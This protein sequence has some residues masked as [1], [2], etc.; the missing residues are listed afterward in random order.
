MPSF[1]ICTY[2]A[3]NEEI[4]RRWYAE[5]GFRVFAGADEATTGFFSRARAIN[6]AARQAYTTAPHLHT[7][8]LADND[9]IPSAPH[10]LTALE[11]SAYYSCITP[12]ITTLHTS[13]AGRMQLLHNRSTLLY[14]PRESGSRS[15]VVIRREVFDR[16]NGMDEK[17]EG[18]GPEDK[19]FLLN[20]HKQLGGV[21]E[22]DG[23]R[24]H[25]WHP[26]DRSKA[27]RPQLMRN[28]ARCNAYL[29]ADAATANV[30]SK[31]YGDWL[32]RDQ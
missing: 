3:E 5:R 11:Q 2:R 25:L 24:L 13:H 19:A 14:R 31:E 6:H 1:G 17:F 30:L 22:L 32:R 10:L 16:V 4:V 12:H 27:N 8:I 21:L 28:R 9:L 23:A 26:G 7:Y 29:E 20:I 15:Y 18:W